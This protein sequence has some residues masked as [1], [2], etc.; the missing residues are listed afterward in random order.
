[1]VGFLETEDAIV[2]G[3]GLAGVSCAL[4]LA[5]AG[6]SVVLIEEGVF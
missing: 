1:M 2:V 3:G 5:D 6:K 4:A